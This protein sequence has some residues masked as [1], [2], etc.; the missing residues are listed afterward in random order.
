MILKPCPFCGNKNVECV[1]EFEHAGLHEG[2]YHWV[3]RCNYLK[4]GCGCKGGAREE[5]IDAVNIWNER[6]CKL[7]TLC[8]SG[9]KI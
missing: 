5:W 4:G 8:L 7:E 3:V 1:E 9:R 2:G 6:V